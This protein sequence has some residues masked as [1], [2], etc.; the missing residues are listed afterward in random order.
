MA[1]QECELESSGLLEK[2]LRTEGEEVEEGGGC[3]N[4][5]EL[6]SSAVLL[7]RIRGHVGAGCAHM[8]TTACASGL[9][10]RMIGR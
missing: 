2:W 10:L 9:H 4:D 7:Q 8:F 5:L 1:L 6:C 3:G